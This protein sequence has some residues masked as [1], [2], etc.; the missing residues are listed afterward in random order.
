MTNNFSTVK[1]NQASRKFFLV[2]MEPARYLNDLLVD[3][4]GGIYQATITGLIISR[5]QANGVALTSVTTV[6]NSGEYSY[7]ESTGI[8]RVY[9]TPSSTN[10]IVAFFYLF[11]TGERF[12]FA[13]Q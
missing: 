10:A 6:S 3:Q 9:S 8:F 4:G 13:T 11:Y 2:R 5:A 1:L 12:R 7:V